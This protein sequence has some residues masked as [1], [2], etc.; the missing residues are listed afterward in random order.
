M[1]LPMNAKAQDTLQTYHVRDDI[2][3][4]LNEPNKDTGGVKTAAVC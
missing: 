4:L 3:S 1:T 2:I